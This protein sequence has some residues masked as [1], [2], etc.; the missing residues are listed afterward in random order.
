MPS[1]KKSTYKLAMDCSY[2]KT[3]EEFVHNSLQELNLIYELQKLKTCFS[4]ETAIYGYLGLF[5]SSSNR[6]TRNF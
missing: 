4:S 1:N 6:P 2:K 3:K 5:I